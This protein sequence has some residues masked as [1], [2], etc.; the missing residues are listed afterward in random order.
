MRRQAKLKAHMRKVI[1]TCWFQG[2]NRAP[3]LVRQCLKSLEVVNPGWEL[4]VLDGGD[5]RQFA[6]IDDYLDLRRQRLKPAALADVVR[7]SLLQRFGGVW[8]DA[9]VLCRQPLDAWLPELMEPSGFF[10]F[11]RPAPDRPLA[12]WLLAAE[13]DN[14]LAA[15]W[16][17]RVAGYWRGRR[18]A[19]EY[20][21][22][23]REF[24]RLCGSDPEA[25]E[26][27]RIT[28]RISADGPHSVQTCGGMLS[29]DPR[30]TAG[31]DWSA[32]VFKLDRRIPGWRIRRD[33]LLD[34]LL[35]E[36]DARPDPPPYPGAAA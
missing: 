28:P 34:R 19:D 17:M 11:D 33:C 29:R 6:P 18:K 4:K 31:V 22:F 35:R 12:S 21:W 16:A 7:I 3:R 20:Y 23:H 2:V 5:F 9:T 26:A 32:P 14:P 24:D 25:A 10:A 8:A 27:W 36:V 15:K 1:W 30:G 13:P